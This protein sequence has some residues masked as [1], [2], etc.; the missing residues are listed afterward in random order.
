MNFNVFLF[1][2]FVL[3]Y[4]KVT[5]KEFSLFRFYIKDLSDRAKAVFSLQLI[6]LHLWGKTL[7]AL[8]TILHE[9]GGF[10]VQLLGAD[11]ILG[12]V[13]IPGSVSADLFRR[14]FL[15]FGVTLWSECVFHSQISYVEILALKDDGLVGQAFGECL[16]HEHGTLTSGISSPYERGSR[17]LLGPFYHVRT[18]A[19]SLPPEQGPHQT[20]PARIPDFQPPEPR[21]IDFCCL[22]LAR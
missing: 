8:N 19:S 2:N 13:G 1:L 11:T 15:W 7:W 16:S 10:L 14:L 17:E 4:S 6:I 21:E 22:K 20:M 5:W 18:T 3:R 9:L 12:P